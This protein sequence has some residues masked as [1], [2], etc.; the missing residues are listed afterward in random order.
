M[1]TYKALLLAVMV[2]GAATIASEAHAQSNTERLVSINENTDSILDIVTTISSALASIQSS[3]DTLATSLSDLSGDL[4]TVTESSARVESAISGFGPTLN[5]IAS[6]VQTNAATLSDLSNIMAGMSTDIASIQAS[7]GEDGDSGLA[8]SIDLLT[9]TVNRNEITISDRLDAIEAAISRLEVKQDS[10]PSPESTTNFG[11]D[12]V[13]YEVN[14]YTYKNQGEKSTISGIDVYELDLAFS[15][16][17]LVQ[18]DEVNTNISRFVDWI[19]TN[20]NP[21]STTPEH[22]LKVDGNYLYNSRFATSATQYTPFITPEPID[23]DLE[24]L[25]AG[26]PLYFESRQTE[27]GS[28]IDDATPRNSDPGYTITV[29][30]RGDRST[31]CSFD[32][33]GNVGTGSLPESDS[34]LVAPEV[35]PEVG[36]PSTI[37]SF[38]VDITCDDDPVEITGM[39]AQVASG[40]SPG[41]AG[42]STFKLTH[43][44]SNRVVDIGFADDGT[45]KSYNYPIAFH[46]EDIRISGKIASSDNVTLLIEL[47]YN[48]VADGSC[49]EK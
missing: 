44:D 20:P 41:L 26:E 45:L 37:K 40:W 39:T 30:Y 36:G 34:L 12:S 22:Y 9:S 29:D 14:A 49:E 42:F 31:T 13:T 18:I 46:S 24:L 43:L 25:P 3:L 17:G 21:V 16:D 19:I 48:T 11:R 7:L 27:R 1:T 10:A 23:F 15:C 33:T 47:D 32:G 38:S 4:S 35:A 6:G 5:T 28:R 2:A 8:E